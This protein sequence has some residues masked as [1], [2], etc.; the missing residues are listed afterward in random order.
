MMR[1]T[2]GT[3]RSRRRHVGVADWRVPR[4]RGTAEPVDRRRCCRQENVVR[5]SGGAIVRLRLHVRRSVSAAVDVV[6]QQ[7]EDFVHT[8][9]VKRFKSTHSGVESS[10]SSV[11]C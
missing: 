1:T 10:C 7:T 3:G 5:V 8:A 11:N 6:C 2:I 4:E 9:G